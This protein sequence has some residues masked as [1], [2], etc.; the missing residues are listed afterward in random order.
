MLQ[1]FAF[2]FH[3]VALSLDCSRTVVQWQVTVAQNSFH[4]DEYRHFRYL[5]IVKKLIIAIEFFHN[6]Q[7]DEKYNIGNV[8]NNIIIAMYTTRR[9]LIRES[10]YNLYKC[11]I[12]VLYAWN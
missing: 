4:L 1:P 8:V 9:V 3:R 2:T 12:I 6:S 11:L 7:G 10:F 5:Q